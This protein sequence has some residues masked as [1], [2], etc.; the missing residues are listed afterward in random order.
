MFPRVRHPVAVRIARGREDGQGVLLRIRRPQRVLDASDDGVRPDVARGR[1][2]ADRA[3]LGIDGHARRALRK[4]VR[5]QFQF[6]RIRGVHRVRI[7]LVFRHRVHRRALNQ[8]LVIV[9]RVHDR[10]GQHINVRLQARMP[11]DGVPLR[12]GISVGLEYLAADD[13]GHADRIGILEGQRAVGGHAVR[14]PL[15]RV[16]VADERIRQPY[17]D[18]I[19]RG[20]P[21]VP[22]IEG[23]AVR[24]GG[25]VMQF[26]HREK[27]GRIRL[28][29]SRNGHP[30]VGQERLHIPYAAPGLNIRRIHVELVARI[31]ELDCR[32]IVPRRHPS[33]AHSVGRKGQRI[34]GIRIQPRITR[35]PLVYSLDDIESNGQRIAAAPGPGGQRANPQVQVAFVMNRANFLEGV[36]RPCAA[37][38]DFRI[39]IRPFAVVSVHDHGGGQSGLAVD[40]AEVRLVGPG[41]LPKPAPVGRHVEVLH[42]PDGLEPLAHPHEHKPA[43]AFQVADDVE[44]LHVDRHLVLLRVIALVPAQRT[45]VRVADGGRHAEFGDEQ[46]DAGRLVMRLEL[47]DVPGVVVDVALVHV[48]RN[49]VL[50]PHDVRVIRIRVVVGEVA[51]RPVR[52]RLQVVQVDAHDILDVR[53]LVRMR[54]RIRRGVVA[55]RYRHRPAARGL[56]RRHMI[57]HF[58]VPDFRRRGAGRRTEIRAG[59]RRHITVRHVGQACDLRVHF[60]ADDVGH[61]PRTDVRRVDARRAAREHIG[62][63]QVPVDR[64]D[65]V[66]QLILEALGDRLVEEILNRDVPLLLDQPGA[67]DQV[68]RGLRVRRVVGQQLLVEFGPVQRVDPDR[69]E[70]HAGDLGE[71]LAVHLARN[72]H[73]ARRVA[74]HRGADVHAGDERHL[75]AL[76]QQD[77]AVAFRAGNMGQ[78]GARLGRRSPIPRVNR[79]DRH[80]REFPVAALVVRRHAVEVRGFQAGRV[81][82]VRRCPHRRHKIVAAGQP[83]VGSTIHPVAVRAGDR[84]PVQRDMVGPDRTQQVCRARRRRV[85]IELGRTRGTQCVRRRQRDHRRHVLH[86]HLDRHRS[87]HESG[88]DR[89]RNRTVRDRQ[90]QAAVEVGDDRSLPVLD[91]DLQRER[92]ADFNLLRRGH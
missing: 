61:Q 58:G 57:E 75:S 72:R 64:P 60:N 17:L 18:D 34:F 32:V 71:P 82:H 11:A 2:P 49:A 44:Q 15:G 52:R 74:R 90:R 43:G 13:Y 33:L 80:I 84:I 27:L 5:Q 86:C 12:P 51:A 20:H 62:P 10:A 63:H 14:L 81:V 36:R 91:G 76:C 8:R 89:R 35:D 9:V 40:Q 79:A 19:A 3:G 85:D 24:V 77:Y 1:R 46:R 69:P 37:I 39:V 59:I 56:E 7:R 70:P 38:Q 92:L 42:V 68:Q 48:V 78:P 87:V 4:A 26:A 21:R 73:L 29:G 47:G 41:V 45:V 6:V 65:D 23:F 53:R 30:P 66:L 55:G 83:V 31:A 88:N 50:I 22:R 28:S 67:M 54:Q 16:A 25:A